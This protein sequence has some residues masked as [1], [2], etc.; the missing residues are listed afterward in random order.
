MRSAPNAALQR[1]AAVLP[2]IA[3]ALLACSAPEQRSMT[4]GG[5]MSGQSSIMNR[6]MMMSGGMMGGQMQDMRTIRSLLASHEGIE[7]TVE[8]LPNGVRT[9][10]RSDDPRVTE[11]IRT[12]V[13]QMRDRFD[14]D[15]PIRRM[16]PLFREL[17]ERRDEAD[18][19]IRDIAGGIEVLHTSSNP[20]VVRLIRQHAQHFVNGVVDRGM[21]A[22]MGPT[23]LPEGYPADREH[24]R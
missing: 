22:A 16:D 9:V 20:E 23:P 24:S 15:Q 21:A 3:I 6:P 5:M 19:R 14:R 2:A 13:R 17:F 1:K 8:E 18:L 11:L 10:T 12:H 4:G 7:R